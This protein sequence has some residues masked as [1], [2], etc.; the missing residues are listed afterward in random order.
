MTGGQDYVLTLREGIL[1][2]P[3]PQKKVLVLNS[4]HTYTVASASRCGS[5]GKLVDYTCVCDSGW[6]GSDCSVCGVGYAGADVSACSNDDFRCTHARGEQ[7]HAT[8]ATVCEQCSCGCDTDNTPL[9][10]CD[11]SVTPI[12][13]VC[14]PRYTGSACELCA[15][16]SQQSTYPVCTSH[17]L[18][19][20]ATCVHGYCDYAEGRCACKNYWSGAAC[21][22][23][24]ARFTGVE[25]DRCAPNWTGAGCGVCAGG[26]TGTLCAV[27][28]EGWTGSNC[29]V[30][31]KANALRYALIAFAVLAVV[32]VAVLAVLAIRRYKRKQ[33][34]QKDVYAMTTLGGMDEDEFFDDTLATDAQPRS[35]LSQSEFNLRLSDEEDADF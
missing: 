31:P 1:T 16:A 32:L 24:D 26:W 19:C 23:C 18:A 8:S 20:P 14:G 6:G 17:P 10:A 35:L 7:C 3:E 27:C 5:H 30:P 34:A 13:C 21:D 9:G 28:S 15:D 33:E 12:K 29:D 11:D 4:E 25:C 22:V 2:G